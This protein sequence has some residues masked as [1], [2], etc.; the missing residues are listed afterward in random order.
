[1]N[2]IRKDEKDFALNNEELSPLRLQQD[3]ANRSEEFVLIADEKMNTSS[4]SDSSLVELDAQIIKYDRKYRKYTEVN[5]NRSSLS[6]NSQKNSMLNS[7]NE[8]TSE[9]KNQKN[10]LD[11]KFDQDHLINNLGKTQTIYNSN[12]IDNSSLN[13]N[14]QS[15]M[16][17]SDVNQDLYVSGIRS[18]YVHI[19]VIDYSILPRIA[20]KIDKITVYQFLKRGQISDQDRRYIWLYTTGALNAMASCHPTQSYAQILK[21][22]SQN[23]PNPNFRQIQVDLNRTFQDEPYYKDP[24]VIKAIENILRAYSVRN[25]TIGY[26]QG[27]N[28]IVGRLLLEAFWIF[29]MI[30]ETMMPLDYYSNMVGALIDQKA[31]SQLFEEKFP[32]LFEH[33]QTMGCDPSLITFQWFAC[34]FSYNVP[35]Q[36]LIRIWDLFFLKGVK[37]LFRISFAIIDQIKNELMQ[38]EDFQQIFKTLDMFPAKLNNFEILMQTASKQKYKISQKLIN[39]L[40]EGWRPAVIEEIQNIQIELK[41]SI[42]NQI[43]RVKFLNKFY[44]YN[45]IAKQMDQKI[46]C[47]D[48][49]KTEH[50]EALRCDK[51]WP[52]CLFDFTYKNK[53]PEYFA[54]RADSKSYSIQKDYFYGEDTKRESQ[55]SSQVNFDYFSNNE[56]E[57]SNNKNGQIKEESD[58]EAACTPPMG[59]Y[60]SPQNLGEI[61]IEEEF[62]DRDL[63]IERNH[64]YCSKRLVEKFKQLLRK[65]DAQLYTNDCLNFKINDDIQAQRNILQLVSEINKIYEENGKIQNLLKC[66]K[67]SNSDFT[68]VVPISRT[69]ANSHEEDDKLRY[70]EPSQENQS[71]IKVMQQEKSKQKI[72]RENKSILKSVRLPVCSETQIENSL[73]NIL[74]I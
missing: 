9:T 32:E 64:H 22:C 55:V 69:R 35:F 27:F 45:G 40:R 31:F 70:Y 47:F 39:E 17:Q 54:F 26:C 42:N 51:K 66:L 73:R 71:K 52:V 68:K 41:E 38:T 23:F 7:D 59:Q 56:S 12:Y 37:V 28:F 57:D 43:N 2:V 53:V 1:M 5:P 11:V 67:R 44:L 61:R 63:L 6:L 36:T 3:S 33:L 16:T 25:P 49:N 72:I 19:P 30:I 20:S 18:P 10:T 46:K 74:T 29:V 60:R 14:D 13:A 15:V 34:F 58:N 21:Y 24:R 4:L 50:I 48:I 8:Q 62:Q 65:N